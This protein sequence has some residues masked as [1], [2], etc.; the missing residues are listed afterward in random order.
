LGYQQSID[1]STEWIVENSWGEDWGEGGY[2][3]MMGGKGDT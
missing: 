1:G 2:V 3:K